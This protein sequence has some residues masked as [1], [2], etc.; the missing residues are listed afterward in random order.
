MCEP[1]LANDPR[2]SHH[3]ARGANLHQLDEIIGRWTASHASGDVLRIL[4]EHEV[5]SGRIFTAPD[6]LDD[7]HYAAR[8]MVARI[9]NVNGVPAPFAN[10]VP[11]LSR[12]PGEV[13]HGGPALGAHTREVLAELAGADDA[14]LDR[15]FAAGVVR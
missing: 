1:D 7:P 10:V 15:L 9:A 5:P 11:R 8:A 3:E 2:F 14:E 4:T 13:R 6:M 12:T